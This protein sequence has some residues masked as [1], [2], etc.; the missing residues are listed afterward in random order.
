MSRI[1]NPESAGKE[2]THLTK[3]IVLAVRKLSQQ[4]QPGAE[5]RDMAAYIALALSTIA[6]TID[7]SV[8]AWEKRD[9]WVKAEKF[10]MEWAWTGFLAEKMRHAV[11]DDD[12]AS[13][14]RIAAQV[15]LKLNKI[16][17]PTGH[18]LGQ[19]W[20]GAWDEMQKRD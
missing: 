14:A 8:A 5:S 1:I 2:R 6:E 9:Y 13:I 3:T 4:T 15:A 11:H 18:R 10:R 12:W 19:P 7:T 16:T 17:L 20:L